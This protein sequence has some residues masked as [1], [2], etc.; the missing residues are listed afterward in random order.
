MRSDVNLRLNNANFEQFWRLGD[1]T[2]TKILK[3]MEYSITQI[4][5]MLRLIPNG[6]IISREDLEEIYSQNEL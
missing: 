5:D 6:V 3:K 2:R 1:R 4:K